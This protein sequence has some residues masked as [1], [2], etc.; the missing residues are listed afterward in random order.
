[1][2]K[3]SRY[4]FNKRHLLGAFRGW[5]W[6]DF[7]TP[8]GAGPLTLTANENGTYGLFDATKVIAGSSV[9]VT[10]A[11]PA[12]KAY[13]GTTKLFSSIITCTNATATTIVLSGTPN[14]SWGTLRVYFLY[15]YDYGMPADYEIPS[16]HITES[17]WAELGDLF[18]DEEEVP[19]GTVTGQLLVWNHTAGKY[20]ATTALPGNYSW[21]GA[22]T[23]DMSDDDKIFLIKPNDAEPLR[24][25][26]DVS[27]TVRNFIAIS[28]VV[29][30]EKITFGHNTYNSEFNFKGSGIALF[31]GTIS[32]GTATLVGG[33][34]TNYTLVSPA[35]NGTIDGTDDALYINLSPNKVNGFTFVDSGTSQ[36]I[37]RLST[38]TGA[39]LITLGNATDDTK[40]SLIGDGVWEK[41]GTG[42]MTTGGSFLIGE[43]QFIGTLSDDELIQLDGDGGAVSIDGDLNVANSLYVGSATSE[44]Q[45]GQFQVASGVPSRMNARFI[46]D[47]IGSG[48][49]DYGIYFPS[50]KFT[51]R[52][53]YNSIDM[54]SLLYISNDGISGSMRN[55]IAGR[56]HGDGAAGDDGIF[57]AEHADRRYTDKSG[58]N[59][60]LGGGLGSGAGTP[61]QIFFVTPD[62]E[63]T[64]TTNQSYSTKMSIDSSGSVIISNNLAIGTTTP[65]AGFAG[66]GDVHADGS[67]IAKEGLFSEAIAYGACLE[68]AD[69]GLTPVYT[70]PIPGTATLDVSE[71]ELTQAGV[72]FT[73][74]GVEVGYYLKVFTATTASGPGQYIGATGEIIAMPTA[75][76]LILSFGAAGEHSLLDATAV[77]YIIYPEPLFFVGDHGD[78]HAHVGTNPD[79]SFKICAEDSNNDHAVHLDLVAGIDGNT[80][81]DIE[82]DASTFKGTSAMHI[83]YDATAFVDADTLGTGIDVVIANTGATAGD[84]HVIDVALG[85]PANSDLEVEALVTHEGV[86]PIAQYLGEPAALDYGATYDTSTTTYTNET[87]DFGNDAVHTPIFTED[88]DYVYVA[89]AAK[90]DEINILLNT[91]GSHTI[92]PTFEFSLAGGTWT[93]FTPADDT[94]GFSQN[95]TIRFESDL[96]TNWGQRTVFEVTGLAGAVNYY[97]I[98]IKR[99]RNVL[100]TSP[101]EDTIQ[102]T[103][104][105]AKLGWDKVGRL[106]IKTYSQDGEPDATDLPASKHCFWIDTND[107]SKLYLCYNQSGTIKTVELT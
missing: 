16:R 52:D 7:A 66:A 76:T 87:A 83:N 55:F 67:I 42:L 5:G 48:N 61:S 13:T 60:Y 39:Q 10:A 1:M 88:D 49:G 105:G 94:V 27:G 100:P 96:L 70:S 24:I 50:N 32:D 80:G 90:F 30:T 40:F 34:A 2:Y 78:I 31:D 3:R 4:D 28:T 65:D 20:E 46:R 104:L 54:M 41:F 81:F 25:R 74:E 71:Q 33:V 12:V 21:T 92:I 26:A 57:R 15:D 11:D 8:V 17:M 95:G 58:G 69:N 91:P 68:V 59:L 35:I 38:N 43:D 18:Q 101:I 99:T 51:I 62:A 63:S 53:I 19:D 102:V 22:S 23:L 84:V 89:S 85:D 79:A 77:S 56:D 64:G 29:G 97:W 107:L 72:N 82:Y 47:A 98:R 9:I 93:A 103:A 36:N 45:A 6:Q 73:T 14:A 86:D 37:L 75:T 106:A 44:V